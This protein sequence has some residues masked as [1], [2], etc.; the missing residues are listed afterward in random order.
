LS[1][2]DELEDNPGLGV[3][4][5][6]GRPSVSHELGWFAQIY[7]KVTNGDA[8][9]LVAEV[10]SRI[11]GSCQVTRVSPG[12]LK[13]HRGELSIGI[14][15]D[16]RGKGIGAALLEQA[17]ER[18]RGKFEAI[19]LT[20]FSNNQAAKGLYEKFGFKL[21]GVRPRAIKRGST[22]FDEDMMILTL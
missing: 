18:C 12:S 11:M 5:L 9:L 14:R 20:V 22:Y 10:D 15:K 8:V 19:E 7:E 21:I 4:L 3:A 16:H 13:S 17:V 1:Y 6:S 2:Y